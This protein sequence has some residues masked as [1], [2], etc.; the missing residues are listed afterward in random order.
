MGYIKCLKCEI[1]L[2]GLAAVDHVLCCDGEI[3]RCTC[4]SGVHP[5]HCDLHPLAYEFHVRSLNAESS[6]TYQTAD[7]IFN[8]ARRL[9]IHE[10]DMIIAA[11]EY[12]DFFCDTPHKRDCYLSMHDAKFLSILAMHMRLCGGI[13]K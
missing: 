6:F 9:G 4:G 13:K 2:S 7:K 3:E 1:D 11:D 12:R 8:H 10:C 5:R